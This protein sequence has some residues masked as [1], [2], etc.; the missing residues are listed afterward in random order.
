MKALAVY[1]ALA[2]LTMIVFAVWPDLDL[3]VSH[4]FF[5]R[6]GFIGADPLARFGRDVFRVTPFVVLALY[7]ALWLAQTEWS[8]ASGG[9]RAAVRSSS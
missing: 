4:L 9:R 1:V 3:A 7:A 2:A 8:C 6:G 5:D